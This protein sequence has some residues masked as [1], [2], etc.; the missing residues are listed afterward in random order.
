MKGRDSEKVGD[1]SIWKLFAIWIGRRAARRRR[2][3][4]H[5]SRAEGAL[6]LFTAPSC[7]LPF[8]SF[9]APPL[10]GSVCT[11]HQLQGLLTVPTSQLVAECWTRL[12]CTHVHI[13][14]L[15]GVF[16]KIKVCSLYFR[17]D[18]VSKGES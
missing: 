3:Q 15:F 17:L 10:R 1:G 6:L 11:D 9:P 2:L 12:P 14:F 18:K 8:H 4:P 16:R 7:L 5:G 13:F